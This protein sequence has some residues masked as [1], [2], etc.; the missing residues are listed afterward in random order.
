MN[1]IFLNQEYQELFKYYLNANSSYKQASIK[2]LSHYFDPNLISVFSHPNFTLG[3]EYLK[4]LKDTN[5]KPIIIK[6]I[7][8]YNETKPTSSITSA[9]AIRTLITNKQDISKYVSYDNYLNLEVINKNIFELI[10][11]KLLVETKSLNSDVEGLGNYIRN[12]GDFNTDY[13]DFINK[14][15]NKKYTK[16]RIRRYLIN[17]LINNRLP[18]I[19]EENYLRLI[20]FNSTGLNY[21]N[22]LDSSIKNQIFK[23]KRYTIEYLNNID[24]ENIIIYQ[25]QID[26][27]RFCGNDSSADIFHIAGFEAKVCGKVIG[28]TGRNDTYRN[29]QTTTH[30]G[31]DDDIHCTVTAGCNH[32]CSG[33]KNCF[34]YLHGMESFYAKDVAALS[35]KHVCRIYG[36]AVCNGTHSVSFPAGNNASPFAKPCGK[37]VYRHIIAKE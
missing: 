31:I 11:Y 15:A 14:L 20:G 37:L 19:I 16:T 21:I 35:V 30:Q 34:I 26:G 33:I 3:L 10:K 36:N 29:M 8:S 24:E 7:G 23:N 28:C 12:N 6:R 25:T 32:H 18:Y 22:T 13:N 9:T 4:Y 2:A 5:I 27:Y 1:L 17:L